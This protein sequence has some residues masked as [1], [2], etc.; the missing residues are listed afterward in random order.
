MSELKN[1]D[2][3]APAGQGTRTGVIDLLAFLAVLTFVSVLMLIHV[4]LA[5]TGIAGLAIGCMTVWARLRRPE[6]RRWLS[7]QFMYRGRKFSIVSA[8]GV[9][10]QAAPAV[11]PPSPPSPPELPGS[12]A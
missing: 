3:I 10:G 8:W 4:R 2:G 6:R 11:E 7:G 9:E 12:G 5:Y 1:A